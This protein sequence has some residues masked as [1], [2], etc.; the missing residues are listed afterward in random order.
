MSL[1]GSVQFPEPV[2]VGSAAS[3]VSSSKKKPLDYSPR[4]L[5]E[6]GIGVISSLSASGV[7]IY[8]LSQGNL[9]LLEL[10]ALVLVV[11][12]GFVFFGLFSAAWYKGHTRQEGQ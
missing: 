3:P 9:S 2:R 12:I 1:L 5:A 4:V 8:G 11:L 10:V 6:L 7:A